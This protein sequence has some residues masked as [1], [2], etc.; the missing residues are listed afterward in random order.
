MIQKLLEGL[1]NP[2]PG[3]E[4]LFGLGFGKSPGQPVPGPGSVVPL[5]DM[6]MVHL[7]LQGTDEEGSGSHVQSTGCSQ[8]HPNSVNHKN[9]HFS[10]ISSWHALRGNRFS[11][12]F[13]PDKYYRQEQASG[14]SLQSPQSFAFGCVPFPLPAEQQHCRHLPY[15][16]LYRDDSRLFHPRVYY[17]V[18]L[19]LRLTKKPRSESDVQPL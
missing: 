10:K 5:Q 1:L 17:T 7:V 16:P 9:I 13:S 8:P 14:H 18:L 3:A 15:L 6:T 19:P 2:E 12:A 4:E 11:T